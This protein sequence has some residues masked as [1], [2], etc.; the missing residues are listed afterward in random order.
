M[1][2]RSGARCRS[3]F[4]RL[5]RSVPLNAQTRRAVALVSRQ[6]IRNRWALATACRN[7]P[8][9]SWAS[10]AAAPSRSS[11]GRADP[12]RP[13]GTDGGDEPGWS[14]RPGPTAGLATMPSPTFFW[15]TFGC[16]VP[17]RGGRAKHDNG[18]APR[19][20]ADG[21]LRPHPFAGRG[22]GLAQ[23]AGPDRRGRLRPA[24]TPA[25]ADRGVSEGDLDQPMR[26]DALRPN[27]TG[28]S[29]RR[30][31]RRPHSPTGHRSRNPASLT[32]PDRN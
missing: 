30:A 25:D 4:G 16:L 32:E 2:A 26:D 3:N 17:G 22:H 24:G 10:F 5:H 28:Q 21:A 12:V 27:G 20:R 19:A 8:P 9:S 23:P 6:R 11:A 18:Q 15:T 29:G 7:R 31:I 13:R 14:R 1:L